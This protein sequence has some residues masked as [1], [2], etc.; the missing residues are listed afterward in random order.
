MAIIILILT[1][2]VCFGML[3]YWYSRNSIS[4]VQEYIVVRNSIG[5]GL[6][7]A[8][9]VATGIGAWILFAP[10]ETAIN[11]GLVALF[12]YAIGGASPL[13]A[14]WF[15]GP[16]LRS[17]MPN[18]NTLA[19]YV[20]KRFGGKAKILI[21]AVMVFYMFVFLAAELTAVG[22]TVR[23]I[24]PDISMILIVSIVGLVTTAYTS[25]GG[26]RAS[27]FTDGIQFLIILPL[28]VLLFLAT[29]YVLGGPADIINE[30][31]VN[32]PDKLDLGNSTGIATAVSLIIAVLAANLFHQGYWQRIFSAADDAS[33][34]KSLTVSSIIVI[35]IVLMAGSFG[36]IA[37]TDSEAFAGIPAIAMFEIVGSKLPDLVGILIIVL[38]IALVMS[39]MDTLLNGIASLLIYEI[40]DMSRSTQV[41]T[42]SRA[43]TFLLL[44]PAIIIASREFSVLYMFFIADLVAAGFIYPVFRGMYSKLTRGWMVIS[45]GF[46]GIVVSLIFFPKSDWSGVVFQIPSLNTSPSLMNSFLS[47]LLIS[48]FTI[49]VLEYIGKRYSKSA[50]YDFD[51]L[52]RIDRD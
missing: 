16:K 30:V 51:D 27:I 22:Q 25:Y 43:L 31:R 13:I 50:D 52:K 3:G 35:P 45:S 47:C 33:L 42:T 24:A 4:N 21:L 46:L 29:V 49:L 48:V 2:S 18:G 17:L 15:L 28:I 20:S 38:V 8:T 36:L 1:I 14:F 5:S 9:F 7:I 32:A 6:S 26:L 40:S 34:K 41:L 10:T 19:E 23:L 39:S 12:G 11:F 44:I 37:L